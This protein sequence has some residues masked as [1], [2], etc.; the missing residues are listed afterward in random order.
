MTKNNTG[1]IGSKMIVAA[2]HY[3][4]LVAPDPDDI[5]IHSIGAALSKICRFGGHVPRFYSVAEHSVLAA[6][7]AVEHEGVN[8]SAAIK[9]VF[10]HDAAEAY[11]GDMIRPLKNMMGEFRRIERLFER[12][13]EQRFNVDFQE[14]GDLIKRV[15]NILLLAEKKA[16]FPNDKQLWTDL[17]DVES[18]EIEFGFFQ[19]QEAEII[20]AD[21]ADKLRCSDEILHNGF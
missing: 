16:L 11:I 10:L 19:P 18:V 17:K 1:C 3:V 15:D 13:I 21:T 6:T 7:T 2:G 20:F 9:A 8:C 5:D 14:H 12:A 4:D